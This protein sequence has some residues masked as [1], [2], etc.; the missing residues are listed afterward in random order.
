MAPG[1]KLLLGGVATIAAVAGC[2]FALR[3]LA[4]QPGSWMD[5]FRRHP[6]QPTF[7]VAPFLEKFAD[8]GESQWHVHTDEHG[9]RVGARGRVTKAG[10]RDLLV[11]G[12]SFTFGYAVE[13]E[14]SIPARLDVMAGDRWRVINAGQPAYGPQQY[15]MHLEH[16]LA[17]GF[18]P[19]AVVLVLF[20]G[21]DLF[22][23]MIDKD[24]PVRD[25]VIGNPGG[26]REWLKRRSHLYRLATRVM[27]VVWTRSPHF[28]HTSIDLM[29]PE[30]W[31]RPEI[32]RAYGVCRVE[33][34][35]FAAICKQR[36]I[37]LFVGILPPPVCVDRRRDGASARDGFDFDLPGAKFAAACAEHDVPFLDLT[38]ALLPRPS[39]E[40]FLPFDGHLSPLGNALVARALYD[41]CALLNGGE[42]GSRR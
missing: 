23:T 16:L 10:A 13:Y 32:S 40:T 6:T 33:I 2:E 17:S 8:T 25:G 21:N 9:L 20:T 35:K 34:G 24:Q 37:D 3:V 27:H 18:D 36:D 22:D 29:R 1:K 30:F 5:I 11:I 28:I 41:G 42:V 7:G 26:A 38:H 15:R 19:D 39:N 14:D 31:E 4:P 12:D